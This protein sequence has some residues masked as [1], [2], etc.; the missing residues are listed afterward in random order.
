MNPESETLAS[1]VRRKRAAG[2]ADE[3]AE[4]LS[5]S[6]THLQDGE[7]VEDTISS[8]RWSNPV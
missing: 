4:V 3:L 2:T 5:L 1:I 8:Y 6:R 7:G